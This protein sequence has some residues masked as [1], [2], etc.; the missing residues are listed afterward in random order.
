MTDIPTACL[1]RKIKP[2]LSGEPKN[3]SVASIMPKL[4]AT[5]FLTLVSIILLLNG[6]ASSYEQIEMGTLG[7]VDLIPP[8]NYTL[9]EAQ[10]IEQVE[11]ATPEKIIAIA[12]VEIRRK[13]PEVSVNNLEL[14]SFSYRIQNHTSRPEET[15]APYYQN[16]Q[17]YFKDWSTYQVTGEDEK[18]VFSQMRV[19]RAEFG[20][21]RSDGRSQVD[22]TT[23]ISRMRTDKRIIEREKANAQ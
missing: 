10:I 11:K 6:C 5:I 17:V 23:D 16:T 22:I 15:P 8:D 2:L 14:R 12:L 1:F 19:Y 3:E 13:F 18:D 4:S 20:I 21:M 9:T 7:P